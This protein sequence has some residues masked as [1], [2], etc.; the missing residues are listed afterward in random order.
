MTLTDQSNTRVKICCISSVEE[1]KLAIRYGADAI[2]LVSEMP[3]GPGV[4][5]ERL[6]AE[7]AANIPPGISSFLLTSR[8]SAADIIDQQRRLRVNT[9]QI[10][11]NLKEGT[12][13]QL[14]NAL[15]GI[16]LVQVIHV[17]GEES[18]ASAIATAPHVD[19]LLLDS[20][21]PTLAV[22]ELGGTGRRHNWQLSRRIQESVRIPIFLAGGLC[23]ENAAVAISIVHPF[24]VD[25]CSGVRTDGRLDETK[26][27]AFMAAV[28]ATKN[29]Q[30]HKS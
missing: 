27:A 25:V 22:K 11:D 6:I 28:Q 19:A 12:H 18:I 14:R 13:E 20:G 26:L 4:I 16:S 1:A 21:D 9:I 17:T 29:T 15:S 10:C 3:S 23:A 24:A 2:G 8:Q 5:S 7:I 30:L